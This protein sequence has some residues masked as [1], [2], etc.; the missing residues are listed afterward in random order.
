M[1]GGITIPDRDDAADDD[2]VDDEDGE[3]PWKARAERKQPPP[4]NQL[5]ERRDAHRK[6]RAHVG[7]QQHAAHL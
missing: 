2:G 5:D 3:P 7:N 6:E 1:S 4:F